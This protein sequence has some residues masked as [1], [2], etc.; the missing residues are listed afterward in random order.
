VK[1]TEFEYELPE[2]LIAQRPVQARDRSRLMVIDR[3]SGDVLHQ[4]FHDLPDLVEPED[5]CVLNNTRVFPARLYGTKENTGGRFEVFLVRQIESV[6]WEA[7]IRPGRRA[8]AGTRLVFRP[9][10]FEAE[11]L[12]DAPGGRRRVRFRFRGDFWRWI[13]QLGRVPLP[14]YIH[15]DEGEPLDQDRERYQTVYA[16]KVGSIAAPTA[17]LHFTEPLLNR[18]NYCEITLHVGYGTFKPILVD[19][20]EDHL[21]EEEFYSL[22]AE[23]VTQMQSCR[24][25][26][27]RVIAVGTTTTRAL[28]H[29]YARH[30][31]IVESSGW[32]DLFIHPGYQFKVL[33]GLVTN[34]HLPG[35]TLLLLVSAFAGTDLI[36]EAYRE[37]VKRRYRFYSYGD[38]MLIR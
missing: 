34:F 12:G 33:G 9:G 31:E 4:R 27:H 7:L 22:S 23:A 28:E 32:T 17:G 15:R 16:T 30:G 25:S 29:V 1:R 21:M 13:D 2:E 8:R 10:E 26:G 37:A 6:D 11:I 35:S 24:D 14:P 38:A 19:D 20:I 3:A 36:R 18:L 5:L